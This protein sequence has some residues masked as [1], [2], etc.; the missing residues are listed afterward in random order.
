MQLGHMHDV[1]RLYDGQLV[2]HRRNNIWQARVHLGRGTYLHRSLKT[3]N[4]DD[5]KRLGEELWHETRYEQRRGLPVHKRTLSS[6]LDEYVQYRVRDNAIG[7][8][9]GSGKSI[10][11]TSDEMLRQVKR[12]QRF[13]RE[14]AGKRPI[15][16][17]DKKAL[18]D[19][20][21]WR[22]AYYHN[23][24][25]MP[26]HAKL[27]PADKTLQWEMVFGKMVLRYAK[28]RGYLGD[29]A[30]PSFSFK[31]TTKRVRPDFTIGDFGQLKVALTQWLHRANSA[32]RRASRQL[33]HDYV[34]VLALSGVRIGEANNLKVRDVQRIRDDLGRDNVQFHVRGKTGARI[35]VPHI[36]AME[37]IRTLLA[38]RGD[39]GPDE[40]LF[41]MAD[42]SK[43][44]SLRD[45]FD[46][47]LDEFGLTYN[48]AGLKH[49]LYSLRHFYA[50]RA[51]ARDVD[52]Y[53]IARN[54][55]TSVQMI[56]QYY[57]KH[58]MTTSQATKLGGSPSCL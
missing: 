45:Q 5:A 46:R 44:A 12:V 49:S 14:Y 11:Y 28:D 2:L 8:A 37:V 24:S 1:T 15:D 3:R 42:G 20:V 47:L 16:T 40:W 32:P 51:I 19:Y 33:L 21:P 13:W 25:E 39:P 31:L 52:V 29:K 17:I 58:A 4:A 57:G 53:T 18:S 34:L 41:A 27:N 36:D 6:V 35:V 38:R 50:V 23:K 7:K 54:M 56:E 22:K 30:I 9:P 55:G 43:I 10:R 48:A 26:K